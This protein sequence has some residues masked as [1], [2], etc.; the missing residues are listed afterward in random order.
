MRRHI[1]HGLLRGERCVSKAQPLSRTFTATQMLL[2]TAVCQER[3]PGR[4]SPA[5]QPLGDVGVHAVA[6]DRLGLDALL[7]DDAHLLERDAVQLCG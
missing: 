2:V 3:A 6:V 7:F 5:A 4:T 1:E